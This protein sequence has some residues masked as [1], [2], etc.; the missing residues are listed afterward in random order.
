MPM[1]RMLILMIAVIGMFGSDAFAIYAP[2][3][4]RF[5]QRDPAG[6]VDGLNLYT[7]AKASPLVYTDPMGLGAICK[8]P[9][10][11]WF[12]PPLIRSGW[13]WFHSLLSRN[14][15]GLYHEHIFYDDGGD[16]PDEG[17][18]PRGI[19]SDTPEEL[20]KYEK[21]SNCEIFEDDAALRRA[22]A[23]CKKKKPF[24]DGGEG[25]CLV[26]ANGKT[27]CQGFTDCVREEYYREK[28]M[29]QYGP[30]SCSSDE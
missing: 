12:M 6:Y 17:Y 11:A 27:N 5:M 25:Y 24:S 22:S 2:S 30:T 21:R 26:P 13:A 19:F 29:E 7:Y 8:R 9:L 23:T 4:G 15:H 1:R 18:S 3:T 20:E 28:Q 16:V 14:N 10:K